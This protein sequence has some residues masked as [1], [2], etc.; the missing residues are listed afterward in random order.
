MNVEIVFDCV[1]SLI[2]DQCRADKRGINVRT[3]IKMDRNNYKEGQGSVTIKTKHNIPN[4]KSKRKPIRAETT[5]L[6]IHVL[7]FFV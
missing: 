4:T 1:V 2:F 7:V 5:Q 3:R 6:Q